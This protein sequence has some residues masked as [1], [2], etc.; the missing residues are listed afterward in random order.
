MAERM[1]WFRAR[2]S[3]VL[4]AGVAVVAVALIGV[5]L[6]LNVA[7]TGFTPLAE[8]LDALGLE[9]CTTHDCGLERPAP[10]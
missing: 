5:T 1:A 3:R 9:L 4:A 6:A 10:E 8:G 2:R 7:S